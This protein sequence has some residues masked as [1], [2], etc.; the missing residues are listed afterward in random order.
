MTA[1]TV[2]TLRVSYV[3]VRYNLLA[4]T[5]LLMLSHAT[6]EL[7]MNL[8]AAGDENPSVNKARIKGLI[9]GYTN[10]DPVEAVHLL[11]ARMEEQPDRFN[12]VFRVMPI[13][14]WVKT[15]IE[16]ILAEVNEQKTR[17]QEG[18]TFRVTLEKRRTQLRSLEVIEPVAEVV[19]REVN[20]EEPDWVILIQI[21]GTETGVSTVKPGDLLNVQKE[22]YALSVKGH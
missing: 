16:T 15:D 10:F 12:A 7:W 6:S 1:V 21:L 20:L 4:T 9:L 22:K 19:D 14:K 18:E 2:K 11:R 8:R 3:N 17:I 13:Q 5:D